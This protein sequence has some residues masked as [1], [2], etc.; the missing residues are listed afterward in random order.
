[1]KELLKIAATAIWF[2]VLYYLS[3]I[4]V[5]YIYLLVTFKSLMLAWIDAGD[6]F[7]WSAEIN[8][9]LVLIWLSALIMFMRKKKKLTGLQ[10]VLLIF[11]IAI[12]TIGYRT[13]MLFSSMISISKAAGADPDISAIVHWPSILSYSYPTLVG[14]GVAIVLAA[15]FFRFKNAL[16]L[17]ALYYE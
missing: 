5:S 14:A 16:R 15:I 9:L 8:L 12:I 13:L 6:I 4:I 3:I 7:F 2:M 11:V 17:K 1:M 10:H